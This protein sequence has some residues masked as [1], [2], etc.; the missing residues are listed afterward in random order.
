MKDDEIFINKM[1]KMC[2]TKEQKK[3]NDLKRTGF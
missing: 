3:M 2:T 1:K